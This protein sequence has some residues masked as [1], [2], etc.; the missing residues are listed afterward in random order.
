MKDKNNVDIL[1]IDRNLKRN[2]I[3]TLDTPRPDE[4]QEIEIT[5][6][7]REKI[8]EEKKL[9]EEQ[10][11]KNNKNFY[12]LDTSE[13][14]Q[15]YMQT[16][17]TPIKID[18]MSSELDTKNDKINQEKEQLI[19]DYLNVVRNYSTD[20]YIPFSIKEQLVHLHTNNNLMS[21]EQQKCSICNSDDITESTDFLGIMICLECG[22]QETTLNLANSIRL[23]HNDS[24]RVNL[25]AK[26]SYDKKSH[27]L[28]CINQYQGKHKTK[29]DQ[30]VIEL[31]ISELDKYKL[32]DHSKKTKREKFKNVTKEH[33]FLFIK[34]LKLTKSYGDINLIFH[35]ITGNPLQ[36][37]THLQDKLL[38]DFEQFVQM[39]FKLFP[40]DNERKNFNYQH[41]LYQL[42][43]R[44]KAPCVQSDFNFLKT[45]ERKTYHDHICQ[46]IFE[47][48]GWNYT[49]LF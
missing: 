24:K 8:Q 46:K 19:E 36:D 23:N 34:E 37:I 20:P 22:H 10:I 30:E 32:I 49:P 35:L 14:I 11:E 29:I 25:C 39:H 43:M 13:I 7:L 48:L 17:Q 47:E 1:Q 44:H 27:F 31:V 41:L 18:F 38:Q 26:Y 2:L 4:F 33:I 9:K 16:L 42:L 45:I 28:N 12:L 40:V 3:E 15:N 21:I 6:F 5:D